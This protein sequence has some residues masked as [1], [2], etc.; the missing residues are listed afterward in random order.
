MFIM[1]SKF[2]YLCYA[3]SLLKG[4]LESQI[5]RNSQESMVSLHMQTKRTEHTVLDI[6]SHYITFGCQFLPLSYS[7]RMV[8]V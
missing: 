8:E 7:A 2:M 1:V 3:S 6:I 4:F 5:S